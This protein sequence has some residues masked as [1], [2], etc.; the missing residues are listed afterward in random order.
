MTENSVLSMDQTIAELKKRLQL[1]RQI[2]GANLNAIGIAALDLVNIIRSRIGT[3]N[4]ID[5]ATE[6]QINQLVGILDKTG[7]PR[8]NSRT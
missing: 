3:A 4:K 8:P 1:S 2:P 5:G 6:E 7:V